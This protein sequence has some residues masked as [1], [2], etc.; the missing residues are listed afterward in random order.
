[1]PT[2]YFR[3]GDINDPTSGTFTIAHALGSGLGFF[4]Q[5][6]LGTSVQVGNYQQSTVVVDSAGTSSGGWTAQNI[7]YLNLNSGIVNNSF[8][9]SLNKIPN[10][11]STLNIRF[12]GSPAIRTSNVK[13][14]PYDRTA[15]T[16]WPSSVTVQIAELQHTGINNTVAEQY[17][18]TGGQVLTPAITSWK[19]F[20]K[21][22]T[23]GLPSAS[24]L[25]LYASP[26]PTGT[27]ANGTGTV[28]TIH[29]WYLAISASPDSIG[30]KSFG[31]WVE[32]E[33][34]EG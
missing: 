29:D 19:Q 5:G 11:Q 6:G 14:W 30:S 3:A 22:E 33:Y 16:N 34:T 26:G 9:G 18:P 28:A 10:W 17:G 24:G 31:L 25:T 13:V 27:H 21:T 15:S 8:T 32:L 20:T 2:F 12:S 1:M 7:K 23:S 4:G